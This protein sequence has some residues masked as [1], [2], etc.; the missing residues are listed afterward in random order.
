MPTPASPWPAL[1]LTTDSV[2]ITQAICDVPSVSGHE[3]PLADLIMDALAGAAHLELI[4]DGDTIVARTDLG[5]DRRPHLDVVR[6]RRGLRRAQRPRPAR[7]ASP[8]PLRG[9]LRHPRR[10]VEQPGR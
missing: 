8:R 10:A 9:R 7:T 6:P 4:R 3:T 1:D 5:R 2:A